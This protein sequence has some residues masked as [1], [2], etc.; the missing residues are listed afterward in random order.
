MGLRTAG[1]WVIFGGIA[2][3]GAEQWVGNLPAFTPLY[4]STTEGIS[5]SIHP[6]RALRM[7]IAV[8]KPPPPTRTS[9]PRP[10]S[11]QLHLH[12]TAQP[13]HPVLCSA[14]FTKLPSH[15]LPAAAAAGPTDHPPPC[16]DVAPRHWQVHRPHAGARRPQRICHQGR[17]M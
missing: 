17:V 11:K 15:M 3:P 10:Q 1:L 7:H 2:G 5:T 8:A 16:G 6:Q 9:P 13:P 12:E 14:C 4:S